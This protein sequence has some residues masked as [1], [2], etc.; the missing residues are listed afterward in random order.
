[1]FIMMIKNKNA[2]NNNIESKNFYPFFLYILIITN[3]VQAIPVLGERYYWFIKIY[4]MYVWFKAFYPNH[5]KV[6]L[7]LILVNS[8]AFLERYGYV[9]EGTLSTHTSVDIFFTP[10]PYLIGKGLLW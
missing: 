5:K 2:V 4:T 9:L 6:V 3:L 10:L 8:W 1:M 7:S